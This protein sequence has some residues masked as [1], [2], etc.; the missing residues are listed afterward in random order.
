M[1][2]ATR[3]TRQVAVASAAALAL[4]ACASADRG[5]DD[6]TEG[7]AAEDGENGEDQAAQL[8]FD[9][10]EENPN[11]CNSAEVEQ[12]GEMTWLVDQTADSWFSY[13]IEGGSVYTL[14]MLHGIYPYTGQYE[15]DGQTYA[16]NMDLLAAEPELLSEDPF[17]YE[18]QI[19]DEAVWNDGTPIDIDDFL[20]SWWMQTDEEAGYCEGCTPRATETQIESMEGSDDGK[21]ITVT[22]RE[23]ESNPEWF[24]LYSAH[25]IGGG[26]MPA[27]IAEEQGFDI[28][29]PAELGEYF[30][31]LNETMPEFS[32]GPYI[33]TDGDLQNQ[34]IKEP[35][36]DYYGEDVALDT[37]I[38]QFVTDQDAFASA[39]QNDEVQG[40]AP[41]SF[42]SD[43]ISSLEQVQG[44]N[45]NIGPGP[46]WSHMDVNLNNEQLA[47]TALRQAIFVAIDVDD[48]GERTYG[49]S[50]PDYTLRKNHIFGEESEFF[51]DVITP[52][53]QG[54]GDIEEATSIL[55]DA[56]YEVSED[57]LTLDGEDIGP[58][59]IRGGD[60]ESSNIAMQLIQSYLSEIGIDLEIQT[61]DDLGTTLMEA[62]YDLMIFGWSG[63]PFFTTA[64]DQFWNSASGSNFGGYSNEEVDEL[65]T[66]VLQQPSLEEA[67]ELANEAA[68]IVAE[69]AY[70]LP[71]LESPVYLFV[72]D[73]YANV[74]DN[75]STSLRGLYNNEEWGLVATE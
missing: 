2:F 6:T 41:A 55:E 17:Q 50:F 18:F 4:S 46:S 60:T 49:D 21:T 28:E 38:I 51:E 1:R 3:W 30:Q 19:R 43:V 12:G 20:V 73:S 35:N 15:P 62:D 47:D 58:F 71:L 70:V 23:G 34:I 75:P 66:R 36:P 39:I 48:I 44:V 26:I 33:I 16:Y 65:V 52:L 5:E 25:S 31:Y 69:D 11:D 45:L 59:R 56:G 64:P 37:L 40:G 8:G 42:S 9:D 27:H 24:S 54:S 10:C 13:S 29:D 74:R 57:G 32:G 14:Q 22:L 53:D 61:T 72:Q 7:T 63:S 67:A 68:A